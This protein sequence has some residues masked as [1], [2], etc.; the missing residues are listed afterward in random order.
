MGDQKLIYFQVFYV[1]GTQL[2]IRSNVH[3]YFCCISCNVPSLSLTLSSWVFC[4]LFLVGLCRTLLILG[5]F[6]SLSYSLVFSIIPRFLLY[7]FPQSSLSFYFLLFVL[8]SS[9]F[10]VSLRHI[11]R[12]F[13]LNLSIFLSWTFISINIPIRIFIEFFYIAYLFSFI[14]ISSMTQCSVTCYEVLMDLYI[15]QFLFVYFYF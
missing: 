9:C 13:I 5:L 12:L 11:I 1:T 8:F 7:L 10:S 2:F 3:L 6:L 4:L 15:S 14:S